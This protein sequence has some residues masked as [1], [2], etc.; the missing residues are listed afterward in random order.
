MEFNKEG[1]T[2]YC[3]LNYQKICADAIYNRD[4]LLQAKAVNIRTSYG[5]DYD[6]YYCLHNGWLSRDIRVLQH[7]YEGLKAK[8]D[9][10][11]AI[12][13]DSW[14]NMTFDEA[15][16]AYWPGYYRGR[17]TKEEAAE[18]AAWT[19]AMGTAACDMA[20]CAYSFCDLGNTVGTYD[21]CEGWDPVKGMPF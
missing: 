3:E 11:C 19:C 14:V 21:D 7:D 5:T 1:S 18:Q 2:A 12:R 20:Y 16:A 9:E 17:P 8:A 6:P 15:D 4:W 13:L 10:Y